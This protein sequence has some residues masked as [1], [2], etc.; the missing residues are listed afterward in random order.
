MTLRKALDDYLAARADLREKSRTDYCSVVERH[1]ATWLDTPLRQITPDMVVARHRGIKRGIDRGTDANEGRTVKVTGDATA[2]A[3][4]RI[5]RLLWNHVAERVPDMPIAAGPLLADGD[6]GLAGR[7]R[8]RQ[9]GIP[10]VG[11][12]CRHGRPQLRRGLGTAAVAVEIV[13]RTIRYCACPAA[14][15][16]TAAAS[17]AAPRIFRMT[18]SPGPVSCRLKK[19]CHKGKR[20]ARVPPG[21]EAT[22]EI[23]CCRLGRV[24]IQSA[25][26]SV[27]RMGSVSTRRQS[28]APKAA[29]QRP[30]DTRTTEIPMASSRSPN[31]SGAK[32]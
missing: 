28:N 4:M 29:R 3:A 21:P 8:Y 17:A 26:C 22:N 10:A 7:R 32:A 2:N 15:M 13:A 5:V 11:L 25:P 23:C 30:T 12:G 19:F 27:G 31:T 1:L 20:H 9:I 6:L 18:S 16:L 14:A 24:N